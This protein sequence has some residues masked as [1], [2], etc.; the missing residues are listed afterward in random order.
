MHNYK[1]QRDPIDH[2]IDLETMREMEED[3]LMDSTE[4]KSLHS[5]VYQGNDP[6]KNPWGI[7]MRMDGQRIIWK[8]IAI[9]MDTAIKSDTL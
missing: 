1:N 6:D 9:I 2:M 7:A 3:L 5:W 4:R 8:P